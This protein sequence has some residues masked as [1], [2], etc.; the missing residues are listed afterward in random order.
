MEKAGKL[1]EIEDRCLYKRKLGLVVKALKLPK[2]EVTWIGVFSQSSS[3]SFQFSYY[4]NF[5]VNWQ[6]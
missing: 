1:C 3:K 6:K 2:N 5:L 4:Q